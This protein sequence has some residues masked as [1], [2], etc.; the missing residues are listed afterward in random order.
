LG[1]R[2]F[3]SYKCKTAERFI[4]NQFENKKDY[5]KKYSHKSRH[6]I[7]EMRH[8]QFW[9]NEHEENGEI[10]KHEENATPV[11]SPRNK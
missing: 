11:K 8:Q 3:C 7:P 1:K 5:H 6:N 4:D 9:S 2:L 10:N